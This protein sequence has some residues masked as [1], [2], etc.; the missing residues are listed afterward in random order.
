MNRRS[1]T[2][3]AGKTIVRSRHALLQDL[4]AVLDRYK[5]PEYCGVPNWTLA[6]EILNLLEERAKQK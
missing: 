4:I 3:N 5:V 1:N 2:W 6:Q